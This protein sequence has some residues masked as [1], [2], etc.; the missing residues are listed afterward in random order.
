[1]RIQLNINNTPFTW[2]YSDKFIEYWG[3]LWSWKI[4]IIIAIRDKTVKQYDV[5]G[6]SAAQSAFQLA[7]TAAR[8][9]PG[10]VPHIY[11]TS[12]VASAYRSDTI[13][14]V[15]WRLFW[16]RLIIFV[17]FMKTI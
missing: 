6:P 5:R 7:R 17:T 3:P 16:K 12:T 10:V 11:R 15:T 1:M 14:S 9:A 2:A 13:R 4:D 8:A